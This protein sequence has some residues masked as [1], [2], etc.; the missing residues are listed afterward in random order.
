MSLLAVT[1]TFLGA[2]R[3]ISHSTSASRDTAVPTFLG[4][5]HGVLTGGIEAAVLSLATDEWTLRTGIFAMLEL[6]GQGDATTKIPLFGTTDIH[7]WRGVIGFQSALSLDGWAHRTL[8]EGGAFELT[9]SARHESEH[10]TA[11]NTGGTSPDYSETRPVGNFLMLDAAARV[12]RGPVDVVARV[13]NKVFLPDASYRDG[14]GLDL[15]VRWRAWPRVHPFVSIFGEYEWGAN[16]YPDAYLVRALAGAIV[17][18]AAGEIQ[19]FV[20]GDIG[21]RKGLPVFTREATIGYGV[22]LAF[23]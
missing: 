12:R 16:G 9:L 7:F 18:S 3:E 23:W 17:P 6:E 11:S 1:L 15:H 13:Q 19:L 8:G 5:P 14:P 22:R 2:A 10:Q 20:S 4:A 21:N